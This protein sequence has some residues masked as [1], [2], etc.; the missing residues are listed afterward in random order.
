MEKTE[1]ISLLSLRN[2]DRI[3][4]ITIFLLVLPALFVH[5]W[6]AFKFSSYFGWRLTQDVLFTLVFCTLVALFSRWRM[7]GPITWP[8]GLLLYILWLLLVFSEGVSYYLQADTFNDRF[9]GNLNPHNLGTG[10]HA[11][12]VMIG[13]GLILLLLL[14][15]MAGLLLR[16]LGMSEGPNVVRAPLIVRVGIFITL[17]VLAVVV[18]STPHR[19][20][21]YFSN[22]KQSLVV[23]DSPAT[24]AVY[25]RINVNPVGRSRLLAAPGRNVVLLYMESLERIY[26]D[27]KVFPGLTPNLDRLRKQG[28]DF[29]GMETFPGATYT[30]A[31][32]FASQCGAPLITSP[33]S[34]FDAG[35]GN[36]NSVDTFHAGLVCFG[37]VLHAA[38]Y[39]Q[40]YMGGAPMSFSSKG[41]F[42][43]LHGYD[44]TLGEDELEAAHDGKL[45]K[46]GWG[47]YD[48]NLFELALNKYREL[49]KAGK[50]FNLSMITLDTH[51]PHGRPSAN[52]P[53]YGAST[54]TVLQ[55]T[56]CS[57][58][59][60]GDFIEQLSKEPNFKNTVVVLMSDH[61][62]MRNDADPLYPKQYHRRP[63]LFVL[64]A[65]HGQRKTRI[66]H[67]DVAPTVL[68]LMGVHT[69]ATFIAGADRSA[70]EA[71]DNPL[72]A[73]E[74]TYSVLRK[75]LWSTASSFTLCEGGSLLGWTSDDGF[76]L[77]GRDL[78]M[79]E[80]GSNAVA[81]N[82][83]QVLTFFITHDNASL[84]MAD[85]VGVSKLLAERGDAS[86]LLI[87]PSDEPN[88]GG[89]LFSI[90]WIGRHGATAH[91][92]KVPRLQ[93][94]SI[95]SQQC[96][97]LIKRV[98]AAKT[99]TILDFSKQFTVS[100]AP[101]SPKLD[102]LPTVINFNSNADLRPYRAELNWNPPE[103][104][105]SWT[106]G[107]RVYLGFSLPRTQCHR[108]ELEF[109]VQPYLVASR[110][111]LDVRVVVNDKPVT[112]W[113][114][115]R[116]Q[117]AVQTVK[118]P[119][120]TD[121]AKCRVDM[122]FDF[123]RPGATPPPYPAGENQSA[124]QL[125][126]KSLRIVAP[127][128]QTAD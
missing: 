86:A 70:A 124:L 24:R 80:R 81:L 4:V 38:G 106:L 94:L 84:L 96:K 93:G 31:G 75:V 59:M 112:V 14:F 66:Y 91:I 32:M 90:D 47:L 99:G 43:K 89:D 55:A 5:A 65:G 126:F 71:P 17:L 21:D 116:S 120:V 102:S 39:D 3:L 87:R 113:H 119:I 76:R 100:T 51:P 83:D 56:Y 9:F 74:V 18:D 19:L 82:S 117:P 64:N 45:P 40:V 41:L 79:Q 28:L 127:A 63:L 118:I 7:L 42:Y 23:A 34:A 108:A 92:A 95:S 103:P 68:G 111:N 8:L 128:G 61:L 50:P 114:F 53:R 30:I 26:T 110:P 15:G 88:L 46:N 122:R 2:R 29:P 101:R 67:M 98:D 10:V 33:F 48:S 78:K 16:N 125:Y 11:F 20:A 73:D 123:S 57:D 85:R 54:N 121:D 58:S 13:G 22:Y 72:V 36:N 44:Q 35:S 1:L 77:G 97:K 12:P 25:A 52:C 49:E 107:E 6:L 27:E 69:N 62:E 104:W 115:D 37:D 60:V 105:G 109:S